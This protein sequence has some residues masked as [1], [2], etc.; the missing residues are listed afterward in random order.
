MHVVEERA[1]GEL[2]RAV[3]LAGCAE[4]LVNSLFL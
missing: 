3:E 2:Q 4:F 1:A